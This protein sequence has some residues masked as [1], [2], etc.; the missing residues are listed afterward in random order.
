MGLVTVQCARLNAHLMTP[1]LFTSLHTQ[2]LQ[3]ME[4]PCNADATD[5]QIKDWLEG[6]S[7][8]EVNP[9]W[10]SAQFLIHT[11]EE[12][13][14]THTGVDSLC[15]LVQ[16]MVENVCSQVAQQVEGVYGDCY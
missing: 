10:K 12:L 9:Q 5:E 8:F 11:T 3:A 16:W 4:L 7:S 2:V 6:G 14:L 13:S 15:G 1:A